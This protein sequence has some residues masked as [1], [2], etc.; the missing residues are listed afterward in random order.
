MAVLAKDLAKEFGP[1]AAADLTE[2][3]TPEQIADLYF[4][5]AGDGRPKNRTTDLARFNL[6]RE[7]KGLKPIAPS[8]LW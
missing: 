7:A 2:R 4:V 6:M 5:A 8:W 3:L 1:A